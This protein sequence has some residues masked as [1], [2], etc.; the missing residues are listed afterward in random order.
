MA[1]YYKKGLTVQEAKAVFDKC[2]RNGGKPLQIN[3]GDFFGKW[4]IG[5][6]GL[7]K[8]FYLFEEVGDYVEISFSTNP[9]SGITNKLLGLAKQY[10]F[11]EKYSIPDYHK[12]NEINQA[13][14][15]TLSL[16]SICTIL[17]KVVEKLL[18]RFC[19][20]CVFAKPQEDGKV[21]KE[22]L[23][24]CPTFSK[25]GTDFYLVSVIND[26]GILCVKYANKDGKVF[27]IDL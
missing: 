3:V 8:A 26:Y 27:S 4:I 11:L 7:R 13:A 15:Y 16:E 5:D 19:D 25:N 10:G 18:P 6:V 17:K 24:N 9:D 14:K 12:G 2:L 22:D 1:M 21:S 23:Q 20:S